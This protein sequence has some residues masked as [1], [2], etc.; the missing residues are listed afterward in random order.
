MERVH[1]SKRFR[2]GCSALTSPFTKGNI[3][4]G[5]NAKE[6][7]TIVHF[8]ILPLEVYLE[9]LKEWVN[10]INDMIN[11]PGQWSFRIEDFV[12]TNQ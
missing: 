11:E 7:G 2:F 9:I 10:V 5:N 3:D 12:K 4:T 8:L 1:K 6:S